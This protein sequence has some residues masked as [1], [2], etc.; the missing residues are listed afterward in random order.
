MSLTSYRAAP[1]GVKPISRPPSRTGNKLANEK[2]PTEPSQRLPER[3]T[4][5]SPTGARR[6][7]QRGPALERAKGQ[8]LGFCDGQMSANPPG[9]PALPS[10]A[11]RRSFEQNDRG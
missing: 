9:E 4:R 11:Q 1:P 7:Y 10:S 3:A 2:A 5:A 6:M 8:L